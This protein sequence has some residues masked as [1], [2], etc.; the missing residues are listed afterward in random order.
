MR[1]DRKSAI[2]IRSLFKYIVLFPQIPVYGRPV[3]PQLP[4][5]LHLALDVIPETVIVLDGPDTTL[6][7][8]ADI[9]YLHDHEQVPPQ[10]RKF[11]TDEQISIVVASPTLKARQCA[12]QGL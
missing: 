4:C 2:D 5:Y 6:P 9:Q 7:D 1:S 10:T 8:H 3:H 11:G 12:T